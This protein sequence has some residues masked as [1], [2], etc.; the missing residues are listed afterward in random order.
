M[1][2]NSSTASR[3]QPDTR[4]QILAV[5][6]RRFADTGYDATSMREIAEELGISKPA[7]Y[8][9]FDSKEAIVRAVLEDTTTQM[10]DLVAWA[11]EQTPSK[12]LSREIV[13]RWAAIA[14]RDGSTMFRFLMANRKVIAE[15]RGG[16]ESMLPHLNELASFMVPENADPESI[17]RARLALLSIN[18]SGALGLDI[19]A[20]DQE[21]LTATRRVAMH[22]L[23]RM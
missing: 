15:L 16:K 23:P 20:S 14:H 12:A 1:A 2:S 22:L 4:G 18:A 19:D 3:P 11:R 5:A 10:D 21:I 17:L 6:L 13:D 9:H 8:Y 7:L